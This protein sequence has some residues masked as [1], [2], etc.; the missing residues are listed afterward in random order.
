MPT[1]ASTVP[2]TARERQLAGL[3]PWWQKGQSGN[4]AVR[5]AGLARRIRDAT[6]DGE[7]LVAFMNDVF[8]DEAEKTADRIT[9]ATWLAD[10]CWGKPAQASEPPPS[11]AAE[12]REQLRAL[13]P[14]QR[15]ELRQ[16][17]ME[18]LE[19]QIQNNANDVQERPALPSS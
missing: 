11:D 14:E 6:N 19:G 7:D 13:T 16:R 17:L 18:Q 3:R 4:P 1:F 12:L 2:S 9:A 15:H 8:R 5:P 10:R